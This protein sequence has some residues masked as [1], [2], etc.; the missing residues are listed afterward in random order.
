MS[1]P[2]IIEMRAQGC[3]IRESQFE[4][5]APA[6]LIDS[7]HDVVVLDNYHMMCLETFDRQPKDAAAEGF[8]HITDFDRFLIPEDQ[9]LEVSRDP[10]LDCSVYRP[11][12]G[13]LGEQRAPLLPTPTVLLPMDDWNPAWVRNRYKAELAS[14]LLVVR[15][16]WELSLEYQHKA[17]EIEPLLRLVGERLKFAYCRWRTLHN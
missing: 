12:W 7:A 16:S 15:G 8:R 2:E 1:F 17:R 5:R 13:P 4:S 11:S 9:M 3:P 10:R 6:V 14:D